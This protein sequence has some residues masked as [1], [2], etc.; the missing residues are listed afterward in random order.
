MNVNLPPVIQELPGVRSTATTTATRRTEQTGTTG[1]ARAMVYEGSSPS[2]QSNAR[3]EIRQQ[4][5]AADIKNNAPLAGQLEK[6]GQPADARGLAMVA[7]KAMRFGAAFTQMIDDARAVSTSLGKNPTALESYRNSAAA[8]TSQ[9]G[10]APN[11]HGDVNYLVSRVVAES[12]GQNQEA[13]RESVQQQ[14][15]NNLKLNDALRQYEQGLRQKIAQVG[16]SDTK[17]VEVAESDFRINKDNQVERVEDTAP[18]AGKG[19]T[20]TADQAGPQVNGVTTSGTR[21]PRVVRMNHMQLRLE[22]KETQMQIQALIQAN[23]QLQG[24]TSNQQAAVNPSW[25]KVPG[26]G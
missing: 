17:K 8:F 21:P 22:L 15:Q 1:D 13:V 19:G 4:Q 11:N 12:S 6:I 18:D 2:V 5:F 24:I 10:I 25:F 14:I 3:Q 16:T 7:G 9:A 20:K 26:N 23:K